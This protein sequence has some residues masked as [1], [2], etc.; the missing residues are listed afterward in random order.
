MTSNFGRR[1]WPEIEIDNVKGKDRK[2]LGLSLGKKS[3]T[4]DD[5]LLIKQL[6]SF[7]QRL[8]IEVCRRWVCIR[9]P[10]PPQLVDK[11]LPLGQ[12]DR[13]KRRHTDFEWSH[14]GKKK[15]EIK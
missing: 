7:L 3:T 4:G 1:W 6:G 11:L 12:R 2:T 9:L 5:R 14:L 8:Q 10:L 13:L 15:L